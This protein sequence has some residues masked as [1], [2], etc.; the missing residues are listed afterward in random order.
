M[1]IAFATNDER[2]QAHLRRAGHGHRT[3]PS[4]APAIGWHLAGPPILRQET[5]RPLLTPGEAMHAA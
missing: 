5:A 1:R 2:R 4:A 3:A